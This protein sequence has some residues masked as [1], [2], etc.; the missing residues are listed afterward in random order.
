MTQYVALVNTASP[1]TGLITV[2]EVLTD[3][4]AA[5]LGQEKLDELVRKKVLA[6]CGQEAEEPDE[7][8]DEA[9]PAPEAAEPAREE[10]AGEAEDDLP[11]LSVSDEIVCDQAEAPA[12]EPRKGGRRKSR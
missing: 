10:E 2:G 7:A 11:E 8:P 5:A 1:R 3:R 4:Q 9:A 6:P 12:R